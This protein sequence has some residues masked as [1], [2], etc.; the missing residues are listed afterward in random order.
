MHVY[1]SLC[2]VKRE[3]KLND[4]EDILAPRSKETSFRLR[5][6]QFNSK[7][8][9]SNAIVGVQG[10]LLSATRQNWREVKHDILILTLK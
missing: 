4:F 1:I 5:K 7:R 3:K 2:E 10:G 8:D 6:V 9:E